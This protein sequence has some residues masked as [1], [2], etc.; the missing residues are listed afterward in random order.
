VRTIKQMFLWVKVIL[1]GVVIAVI[2]NHFVFATSAVEG[3]S[4]SPTIEHGERV[5][6]NKVIYMFNQPERGEVIIIE[7]PHKN[8]IKRIVALPGDTIEVEDH[9]LY[10]N[11]QAYNETYLTTESIDN[12]ADFGPVVIPD[13]N[14]FVMGDNR[15]ISQDSRNGL[16]FIKKDDI[17]GR[18]EYIYYPLEDRKRIK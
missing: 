9:T 2:L 1:V 3:D 17:I 16:G 13:N 12:T 10:I 4:M 7:R 8:Y 6:L 15:A 14:Y 18:S 5:V 11:E